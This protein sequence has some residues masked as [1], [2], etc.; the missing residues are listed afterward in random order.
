[1]PT[2]AS[3]S[4]ISMLETLLVV[5]VASQSEAATNEPDIQQIL[6]ILSAATHVW[7]TI[8]VQMGLIRRFLIIQ[9]W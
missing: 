4:S 9:W 6:D 2:T 7:L 5:L 3:Y 1:M 8:H